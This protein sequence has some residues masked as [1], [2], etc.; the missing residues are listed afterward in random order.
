[1]TL[2]TFVLL[3]LTLSTAIVGGCGG[4]DDHEA[5]G[6]EAYGAGRFGMALAEY[7]A[8]LK[9]SP[10]SRVW[11][12][13]GAAALHV[14]ELDTASDAYLRL[15]AEDPTRAEEAAEGLESVA[16]A[17]ERAGDSKRLESA[18]VGLGA[19]APGRSLGRYALNLIRRPGAQAA[20]L[21][22]VLPGA[23]AV[24]PDAETVDSLLAV[25]GVALRETAGCDQ[26]LPLFQAALRRTKSPDLRSRAEE[27]VAACSLA[28]G[29]RAE[30]GDKLQDAA[31]WYAAAIRIDSST[32]VG[33]RALVGYGDARLKLG[34]TIAAALAFQSVASDRVQSDSISQMAEDRLS[35]L[36]LHPP[37]RDTLH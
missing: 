34:D 25:Y 3:G 30:A 11:A 1:V 10:D 22:A 33:R 15:A 29:V 21:V 36:R 8:A 31:L 9:K 7:R 35:E 37:T 26:A 23:I 28:L 32:V 19:I 2:R 5:A 16:R 12:K 17:A 27:G 13:V 4:G 20:D 24:A 18:V 6:D 14:G